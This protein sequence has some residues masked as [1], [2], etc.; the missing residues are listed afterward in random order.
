MEQILDHLRGGM[1][2]GGRRAESAGQ[3]L[4]QDHQ[5]QEAGG[6]SPQVLR[7]RPGMLPTGLLVQCKRNL[8]H[9]RYKIKILGRE[10]QSL[11]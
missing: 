11:F 10:T 9:L 5:S 3:G 4:E 8:S 2:E 7:E 1:G 6:R